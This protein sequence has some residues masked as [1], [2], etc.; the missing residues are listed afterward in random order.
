VIVGRHHHSH[1]PKNKHSGNNYKEKD[2][3]VYG[4]KDSSA[5]SSSQ[6]TSS[7]PTKEL[8]EM[9]KK[10]EASHTGPTS[11]TATLEKSGKT[12]EIGT[13]NLEW[14]G[15]NKEKPR[16]DEDYKKLAQV[17]KDTGAEVLGVEEIG[18]EKGLKKLMEN[19]PGFDYV[20]G[21]TGVRPNGKKQLLGVIYNKER[22]QVVP[23]SLRELKEAQVPHLMGDNHL[24]APLVVDMKA[25]NFDFTLVVVHFKARMD[26][27]T[28]KIRNEQ[29]RI[30][31]EWIKKQVATSPEKDII[32]VGDCNDFVNSTSMKTLSDGILQLTTEEAAAKGEFSFISFKSLIDQIGVTMVNI[33]G[34]AIG[35]A[36]EKY[37]KGTTH[38]V[39]T[40][41]YPGYRKWGSDH[42]PVIASFKSD[43]P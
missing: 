33:N 30:V 39:D 11:S 10:M 16:T 28:K 43:K 14:L 21:T 4:P 9:K 35:G 7:D 41:K 22:A 29:A 40:K 23:G 17:I 2:N 34:G 12:V 37:I 19:L 25:D 8:A 42:N 31:N 1:K 3:M 20:L 27:H 15:D 18:N 24:R 36:V 26:E 32:V 38:V 13:F 6:D 5:L